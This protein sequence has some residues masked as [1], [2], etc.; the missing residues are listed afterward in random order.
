MPGL[1]CNLYKMSACTVTSLQCHAVLWLV[2]YAWLCCTCLKCLTVTC[3][4]SLWCYDLSIM[5]GSNAHVHLHVCTPGSRQL[6]CTNHQ[7]KC[8]SSAFCIN[9]LWRC[10]REVDCP[11]G[12]DELYCYK[13][14]KT[15]MKTTRVTTTTKT[16]TRTTTRT[17]TKPSTKGGLLLYERC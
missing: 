16:T 7:F 17:K 15:T 3:Q 5:P 2:S 8:Q 12:S 11:D 1:H 10:D 13:T 14:A 9:I 6:N 4:K